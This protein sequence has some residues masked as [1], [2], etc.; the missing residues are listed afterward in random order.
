M[1]ELVAEHLI[2]LVD[3][4]VAVRNF[5]QLYLENNLFK[6]RPAASASEALRLLDQEPVSLAVIDVYLGNESG[7]DLLRRIRAFVPVLQNFSRISNGCSPSEITS[8]P[9]PA[10]RT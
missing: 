9:E 6:V 10:K 4:E 5:Y 3:D 1:A 8:S 2:L 7:I